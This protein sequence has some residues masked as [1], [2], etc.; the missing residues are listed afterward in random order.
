MT[1]KLLLY[2]YTCVLALFVLQEFY[3]LLAEVPDGD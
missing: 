1:M 2:V 3:N